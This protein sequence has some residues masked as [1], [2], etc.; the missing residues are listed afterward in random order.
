MTPSETKAAA[1]AEQ[2]RL[3]QTLN[4]SAGQR[5][6]HISRDAL[7]TAVERGVLLEYVAVRAQAR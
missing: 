3:A 7:R 6:R 4:R 1:E 2:K 5:S